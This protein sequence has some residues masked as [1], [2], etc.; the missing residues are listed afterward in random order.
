MKALFFFIL[1]PISLFATRITVLND[2][3]YKL[4]VKIYDANK[5]EVGSAILS[6]NGH[7]YSWT[8]SYHGASN[9]TKGPFV[10]EFFCMSQEKFGTITHVADGMTVRAKAAVGPR[11]CNRES[12]A[13]GY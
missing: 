12:Q 3:Q 7:Y 10:V 8:D 5:Q 4:E 11:F 6:P 2:S 1:F 13:L 9:W